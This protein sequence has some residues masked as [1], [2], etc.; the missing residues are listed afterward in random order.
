MIEP[1]DRRAAAKRLDI[2]VVRTNCEAHRSGVSVIAFHVHSLLF[3]PGSRSDR[4]VKAAESSADAIC[5]DLEDAVAED[6]K[7]STRASVLQ[8][9]AS[10]DGRRTS[11]RINGLR[12]L[13]GLRDLISIAEAG[14]SLAAIFVPMCESV[15]EIEI[16]RATLPDMT[17]CPLIETIAGLDAASAIAG[18]AGV[19]AVMLGGAD[20][21]AEMG[22]E[23][24]WEPLLHA[25][26]RLVMACAAAGVPAIDVPWIV[27]DD[28]EGLENEARAAKA[29]GFT[30]KAAIHPNQ[31]IAINTA[32][33]PSDSE[34]KEAREALASYAAAG[35]RAVRHNGRMLE[36]PIVQRYRQILGQEKGNA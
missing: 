20:L 9:L 21:A 19:G 34:R 30:G 33:R 27:L 32:F 10:R 14:V 22:V 3:V 35:G 12:T 26:S 18:A 11:L 29:L 23:L 5:I 8:M 7:E 6:D 16:V 36:A 17:I 31:V 28:M 1:R 13:H 4:V 15:A 24:G 2:K 25:R